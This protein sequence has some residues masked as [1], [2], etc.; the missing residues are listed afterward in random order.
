[1]G[2]FDPLQLHVATL[3]ELDVRV[4]HEFVH[5]VGHEPSPPSAWLAYGSPSPDA[6][7]GEVR[8][9]WPITDTLP[10]PTDWVSG[11][12]LARLVPLGSG[13]VGTIPFIVR[14]S[15]SRRSP[16]LVEVP[17]NT[18]QAYNSWGGKSLYDFN[19]NGDGI[20]TPVDAGVR[21]FVR[22]MLADL[23]LP[24]PP[25]QVVAR[26]LVKVTRV[27]VRSPDPRITTVLVLRHAGKATF[28]PG[29][30]GVTSVCQSQPSA[31][32]KRG[33]SPACTA[34]RR[35]SSICGV[36]LRRGSASP[37]ACRSRFDPARSGSS[38][39]GSRSGEMRRFA[40]SVPRCLLPCAR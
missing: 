37:S 28:T 1:M 36:G 32:T 3:E 29:G 30:R 2:T 18:W 17:T 27:T 6:A 4:R 19:S 10:I 9:T 23:Q 25:T 20:D 21:R 14:E 11:Y 16:I 8:L 39:C 31:W 7:T 22:N 40:P 38:V 13:N 33:S 34:T 24:A 12:Y 15:D 5:D 26:R 35:S